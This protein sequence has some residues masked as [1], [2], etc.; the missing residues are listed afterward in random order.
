MWRHPLLERVGVRESLVEVGIACW[1]VALD[2]PDAER[3][4]VMAAADLGIT[5]AD[6]AV[7]DTGTLVLASRPGHARLVSLLPPLH[8][9]VL[10]PEA[11]LPDLDALSSRL[12]RDLA[13]PDGPSNIVFVTGPSRTADIELSL[14]RGVHGPKELHVIAWGRG[15]PAADTGDSP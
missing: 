13:G 7:A 2:R 11:L 10:A 8:A 5:A 3:L 1:Q 15:G 14:T 9:V 12:A 4:A 6:Y